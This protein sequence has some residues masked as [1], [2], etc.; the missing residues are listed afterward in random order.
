[1]EGE[2]R[3]AVFPRELGERF[4]GQAHERVGEH[5]RA[6]AVVSDVFLLQALQAID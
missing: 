4:S 3:E 5:R 1:M 6:A 2:S